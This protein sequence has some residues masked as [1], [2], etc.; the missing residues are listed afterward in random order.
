MRELAP[1]PFR[2]ACAHI[3]DI[4]SS[5]ALLHA[6]RLVH[7][8]VSPRNVRVTKDGHAKLFDFGTLTAFGIPA[9]VAGTP[10]CI[11]FEAL[12]GL[13]LDHRADLYSLGCLAYWLLTGRE[14][15]PAKNLDDLAFVWKRKPRVPSHD[16]WQVPQALDELVV[17]LLSRDPLARPASAA[18]VIDRINHIAELEPEPEHATA[19]SYFMSSKTVGQA[20]AL[21]RLDAAEW[22]DFATGKVRARELYDHQGDPHETRNCVDA[23]PDA[24]GLDEAQRLLERTFPRR[25]YR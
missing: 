17:A 7:R 21:A 24:T 20:S 1:M 8:D 18:E 10:S 25:G 13:P 2:R 19:R 22:R 16:N 11:P 9:D 12:N 5:L 6:H 23:P 4:A 3:R 15:Y 14:A